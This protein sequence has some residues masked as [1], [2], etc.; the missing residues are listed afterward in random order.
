MID[1]IAGDFEKNPSDVKLSREAEELIQQAY[2]GIPGETIFDYHAHMLGFGTSGSGIWVNPEMD[3]FF[4]PQDKTKLHTYISASGI[5]DREQG[6]KQYLQR[7]LTLLKDLPFPSKTFVLALDKSYN[8]DG[9][10]NLGNTKVY[11]PNE[12]V[13]KVCQQYP[14]VYSPCISVHPYR[15]DAV[16]ELE[17]W[18]QQGVKLVKWLPNEMAI[19]ASHAACE[20]FYEKMMELDMVLLTH[21]GEEDA[22]KVIGLQHLGNPLL[23]IRPLDMGLKIIMAHCASLGTNKDLYQEGNLIEKN[24][25]LFLRLMDNPQYEGRLFGDISGLVQINRSGQPL[26]AI[27]ERQDIH[28]RLLNGTDYPLPAINAVVSTKVLAQM[29]YL[30]KE[31][32]EPLNDLY[33]RNPLLFDFVLKRTLHHPDDKSLKFSPAIFGKHPALGY[34]SEAIAGA[35]GR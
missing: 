17:K 29:G 24:Y 12:Y 10:E 28:H 30:E 9:T 33:N 1:K 15:K 4:H 7:F 8:E 23:F 21:V 6:D 20:A 11:V 27:L 14:E 22:L 26:Q 13:I 34:M 16:Q 3:S 32:I 25:K 5:A 31:Q 18:A 35:M 2:A 19:D